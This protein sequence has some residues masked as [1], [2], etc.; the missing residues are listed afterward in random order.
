MKTKRVWLWLIPLSLL[1][2]VIHF[3]VAWNRFSDLSGFGIIDFLVFFPMS[4]ISGIVFLLLWAHINGRDQ[5]IIL[6]VGYIIA[7]PFAYL[8]SLFSG[9]VYDPPVIG[10]LIWGAG[11]I[12]AGI[13]LGW[14]ISFIITKLKRS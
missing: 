2:P 6:L 1:W 14:I 3:V 13:L 9:L 7:S 4:I 12:L 11:P 10:T 8:G 5:K